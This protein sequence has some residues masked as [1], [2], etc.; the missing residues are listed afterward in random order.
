MIAYSEETILAIKDSINIVDYISQYVELKKERNRLFGLC[1]F[2]NEDTPSFMVDEKEQ[3]YHCFGCR[4]HGSIFK[5]VMNIEHIPFMDAVEK[6]A[7][8][9]GIEAQPMHISETLKFFK[10]FNHHEEEAQEHKI[11]PDYT[12]DGF[13]SQRIP[14]WE[15]EG[16][17]PEI[18]AQYGV[19]FDRKCQRIVYPVYDNEGNLIN[20]KGRTVLED[21]KELKLPKYI[22]YY[23]VGTMDYLQGLC[24]KKEIIKQKNE[25]IIFEGI[26]SCMKAEGWGFDNVISAETSAL[27][28][29][30]IKLLIGLHCDVVIAFD[31]DKSMEDIMKGIDWLPK[32]TNVY[33]INDRRN[34]LGDKSEKNS[35]VDK[36]EAIWKE[37]YE[38]RERVW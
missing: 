10:Q 13:I 33:V 6:L 15:A 26:K 29:F 34:L 27:N 18:I 5:F 11:L 1:P 38:C 3:S 12:L 17:K 16:I 32:F 30:Q 37:L 8:V 25:V 23:K 21:W 24:F 9:A 20:V 36:G 31:K 28:S 4:A 19:R 2:H 14:Q 7:K 35:P 22:N